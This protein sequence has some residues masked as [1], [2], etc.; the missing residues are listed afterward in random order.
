MRRNSRIV[1]QH[2]NSGVKIIQE[3]R[4]KLRDP[5][6]NIVSLQ[7]LIPSFACLERQSH[8]MTGNNSPLIQEFAI[9][10]TAL[11][12]FDYVCPDP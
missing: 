1:L 10:Q 8:K 3:H 2:V 9:D 5:E 7:Q 4:G 6:F 12:F 11:G